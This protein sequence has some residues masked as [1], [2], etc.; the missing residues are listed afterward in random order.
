M[1]WSERVEVQLRPSS[2]SIRRARLWS[3]SGAAKVVPVTAAI[4]EP[5]ERWREPLQML[6]RV[7]DETRERGSTLHVVLSDHFARF[8]VVPWSAGLVGDEE[9]KAFARM[10][11]TQ[12]YGAVSD[13]WEVA[14]DDGLSTQPAI[15]A[16][17]D[18][19]LLQALR[20]LCSARGMRL[21]SVVPGFVRDVN[22][23]RAQL[24]EAQFWFARLEPGRLT[25][26]LR[27]AGAWGVVRTR[28]LDASAGEALGGALRQEALACGMAPQGVVYLVDGAGSVQSIPGW[29]T[30]RL[31][32]T[33]TS[34]PAPSARAAAAK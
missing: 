32:S 27:Q 28:R 5:G 9:R 21:A 26:G 15:A 20:E 12:V 10:S 30:V 23:H 19:A 11:F 1:S 17:V 24:R 2:V 3:S 6:V 31:G 14:L 34:A 33:A 16:A 22:R 13:G 4:G 18:R 25:V 29:R 8:A 7:F